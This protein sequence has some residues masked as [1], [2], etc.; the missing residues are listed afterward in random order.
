[1][2]DLQGWLFRYICRFAGAVDNKGQG[3]QQSVSIAQSP[4][5]NQLFNPVNL[6]SDR[7]P[8]PSIQ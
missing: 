2:P 6:D 5:M 1:M 4:N 3:I 7:F 8:T